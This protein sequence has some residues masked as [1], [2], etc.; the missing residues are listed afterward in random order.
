MRGLR[1]QAI[2]DADRKSRRRPDGFAASADGAECGS[3]TGR[4][5]MQDA[6]ML[7]FTV[8]FFG[9]AFLYVK[10]CQKLR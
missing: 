4:S 8:V 10:A 1:S 7:L 9:V 3:K 5:R 2:R 6:V